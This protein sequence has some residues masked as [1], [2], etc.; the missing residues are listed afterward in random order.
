M[1]KSVEEKDSGVLL[2][3]KKDEKFSWTLASIL[4]LVHLAALPAVFYFSWLNLL[5][6]FGF[7]LFF[8]AVGISLGHHRMLSHRSVS[9]V[10]PLRDF[11]ALV[12]TLCFQ[13]GP[14]FWATGHRAHHLFT[15]SYGD[16]HSAARGF[17]WSHMGW[18]FYKNP[19]GFSYGKSQR[20]VKDLNRDPVLRFLEK[21]STMVNVVFLVCLLITCWAVGRVELFFWLGP[22]RIVAVWHTTWMINS[23]A[24]RSRLFRGYQRSDLRNSWLMSFILGGEGDHDYHH[25]HPSSVR[26]AGNRL[27]FDYIYWCL[28]G[29]KKLRLVNFR[30]PPGFEKSR[31]RGLSHSSGHSSGVDLSSSTSQVASASD[32]DEKVS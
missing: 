22:L 19:N 25:R 26:H 28:L 29:L 24:H 14:I 1:Q 15:E 8:G 31:P 10:R 30:P 23:Y 3:F 5:C 16:P 18:M 13:G 2:G 9:P 11:V 21:N 12:S 32:T 6:F 27:H 4:L 17:W 7:Y 20:L